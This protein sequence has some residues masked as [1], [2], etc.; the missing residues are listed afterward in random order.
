MKLLIKSLLQKAG[1][2]IVR[3]DSMKSFPPDFDEIHCKIIDRVSPYTMTGKERIHA[4][5]NATRYIIE[6]DIEGDFVECGVW[7]GGSMMAIAHTL[8]HFQSDDRDLYLFDTFE[9]MSNPTKNDVD[10]SGMDAKTLLDK[11][12]EEKNTSHIWCYSTLDEVKNNL[13]KTGYRR[14]K[15][16]FVQGKVEDTIPNTAPNKIALLRL[17]TDWY[18]STKHELIHLYPRVVN[19][20]VIIID[21]YGYWQGCRKAVDE[22]I[23]EN[24]ISIL[25]NRIDFTGRMGVKVTL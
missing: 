1:F 6:N 15:I 2:E 17:D 16:S 9:G 23:R 24:N 13:A 4:L 8:K 3:K 12:E 7:K 11:S 19:G 20:G 18:E 22:Y 5:I 21:D 10:F 25:L 14:D